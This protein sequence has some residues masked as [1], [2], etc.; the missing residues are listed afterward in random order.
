MQTSK[1]AEYSEKIFVHID[2]HSI[3]P[4]GSNVPNET[5]THKGMD[6]TQDQETI[7]DKDL[8]APHTWHHHDASSKPKL[9][10]ALVTLF[11]EKILLKEDVHPSL[12]GHQNTTSLPL[13]G[14]SVGTDLKKLPPLKTA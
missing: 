6:T 2:H 11:R 3:I 10:K 12:L 7:T 13:S 1:T 9:G 4:T 14:L 5:L 8:Y